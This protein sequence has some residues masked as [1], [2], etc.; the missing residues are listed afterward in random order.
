MAVP[1]FAAQLEVIRSTLNT[2]GALDF[3]RLGYSRLTWDGDDS[4]SWVNVTGFQ[5][6]TI[7]S[8][9]Q[10]E[11]ARI[12]PSTL[13]LT[14]DNES[15]IWSPETATLHADDLATALGVSVANA[16]VL[17][18]RRVR[19]KATVGGIDYPMFYGYVRRWRPSFK[20]GDQRVTMDAT[21]PWLKLT[22]YKCLSTDS[23]PSEAAN[24]RIER[25]LDL[26][27]HPG[28]R[29]ACHFTRASSQS[30]FVADNADLSMGAAQ[31]FTIC[32]WG[33]I[34]DVSVA[35]TLFAKWAATGSN[36]EYEL[37]YNSNN[38]NKFSFIVSATGGGG[39]A[40]AASSFGAATNATWFFYCCQLDA[41]NQ[42]KKISIN[43]G[44]LD[45]SAQT[46]AF[47]GTA[48]FRLGGT[49]DGVYFGGAQQ[50]V[51]VWKSLLTAD[52]ITTLYNGGRPL[53]ATELPSSLTA[54]ASLVS[55]WNLNETSGT[56]Y[57][58]YGTND[59]TAV[60]SPSYVD[61]LG[62]W[63]DIDSG[64]YSALAS[65]TLTNTY[66][67][68]HLQDIA[69]IEDGILIFEGDGCATWHNRAARAVDSRSTTSQATFGGSSGYGYRDPVYEL[70]DDLIEN[71]ERIT[72]TGGTEQVA[73]DATSI[74]EYQQTSYATNSQDFAT[75]ADALDY[76]QWRLARRKNP[77]ARLKSITVELGG[78]D[79]LALAVL[80][81]RVSDRITVVN[82]F[83]GNNSLSRDFWV[84]GKR[85]TITDGGTI[86]SV[87]L[88]LSAAESSAVASGAVLGFARVDYDAEG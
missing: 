49:D 59:L 55:Y 69:A 24:T 31:S 80:G 86:A 15:G 19:F 12:E 16:N 27:G 75:D 58:N 84:E 22:R 9:R 33:R 41:T 32:G 54:A 18:R 70:A 10:D 28:Q 76:A 65:R 20:T 61:G 51:G 38:P 34:D 43:N 77:T 11:L 21:D 1:T 13:N 50:C 30:A 72:R 79:A 71:D 81:L 2:P 83:P 6:A 67:G 36:R 63:R 4:V 14:L 40:L 25:A 85:W 39:S 8:G 87:Q 47:D 73:S 68:Q 44:A 57:D 78:D 42:L 60:N 66:L 62:T 23:F 5:E 53:Q 35:G 26:V 52:Q 37:E 45:S 17:P 88:L 74:A 82:T 48:S 3:A 46:I 64:Y 29:Y 7:N 56:R